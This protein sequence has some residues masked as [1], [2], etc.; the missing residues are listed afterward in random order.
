MYTP[1][2]SKHFSKQT[3]PSGAVYYVLDTHVAAQQQKACV[4]GDGEGRNEYIC[5]Y[6]A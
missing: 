1:A 3:D 2:T 5:F 6:I 4:A